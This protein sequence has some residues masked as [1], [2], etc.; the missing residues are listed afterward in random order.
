[1]I[2]DPVELEDSPP[3]PVEDES[4]PPSPVELESD[5]PLGSVE[6]LLLLPSLPGPDDEDEF[7]PLLLSVSAESPVVVIVVVVPLV[8]WPVE[9][10]LSPPL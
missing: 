7:A 4:L 10:A 9:E 3:S 1:M 5:P 2:L 6:E 8:P